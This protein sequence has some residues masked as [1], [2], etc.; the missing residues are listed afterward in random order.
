MLQAKLKG[1]PVW[2]RHETQDDAMQR[3]TTKARLRHLFYRIFYH[4]VNGALV[5]GKKNRQHLLRHGFKPD[6]LIF[7][8]LLCAE[9]LHRN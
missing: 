1:I 6:N 4:F 8:P 3:S 7:R 5:I 2:I 9:P